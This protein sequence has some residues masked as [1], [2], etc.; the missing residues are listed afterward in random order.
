MRA[1][2]FV[3]ETRTGSIQDD[4]ACALPATYVLTKLQNQ[5]PYLQYRFGVAI[6]QAKGR[7]GRNQA[8]EPDRHPF[9][10]RSTWGE[11][12]IVVS[13]DP[14][15]EEWIDEALREIGQSPSDKRLIST[16]RS[17]ETDDVGKV[18]PIKSFA[19]YTR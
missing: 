19:G 18:S 17:E 7:R 6:A 13:Y 4:V 2:E 15:I 14:N 3:T 16:M 12:Q 11:N 9:A 8:G 5:D 10:P 1:R